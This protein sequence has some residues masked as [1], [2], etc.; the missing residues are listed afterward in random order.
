MRLIHGQHLNGIPEFMMLNFYSGNCVILWHQV[1][2]VLLQYLVSSLRLLIARL[3]HGAS[4]FDQ[5]SS[6][7]EKH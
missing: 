2:Q 7:L 5:V 1:L 6:K 4:G 3:Q